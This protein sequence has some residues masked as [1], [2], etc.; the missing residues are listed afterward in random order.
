MIKRIT[1]AYIRTYSDNGQ[2]TVYVEWI[3]H[4]GNKGRTEA[5]GTIPIGSHMSAL[6]NRASREGVTIKREVW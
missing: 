1:K 4:N 2:H 5:D 6:L 3:D